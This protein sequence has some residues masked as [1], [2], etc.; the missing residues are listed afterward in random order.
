MALTK[1]KALDA[2]FQEFSALLANKM[3]LY[4]PKERWGEL[5]KK[6]TPV[7]HAS[8]C[9]DM[10]ACIRWLSNHLVKH[11]YIPEL[12]Y[13]LTIGETYFFRDSRLFAALEQEVLP[14]IIK[15][16]EE[17]RQIRI[18]SAGCCTGE[19]PYS[20]AILL[21]RLIPDIKDWNIH[22][23]ASDINPSFLFK[24]QKGEYSKWSFRTTP[25]DILRRYFVSNRQGY[26][27]IPEIQQMVTFASLN[28]VDPNTVE[29]S[30]S[31]KKMDLILCNN[32]LIYFSREQV[33]NTVRRL[34]DA[35]VTGGWLSVTAIEAPFIDH[36]HLVAQELQGAVLFRKDPKL[37]PK[38]EEA[39]ISQ[40]VAAII[41]PT[42]WPETDDSLL[43]KVV[44]PAFLK[45]PEPVLE[46]RFAASQTTKASVPTVEQSAPS[47]YD[48]CVALFKQKF[49]E[50]T[51]TGLLDCL[52]GHEKDAITLQAKRQEVYLLIRTY[53]NQGKF[54]EA[55]DWCDRALEADR[56]DPILH[57]LQ[58]E[59]ELAQGNSIAAQKALKRALFLDPNFVMAYYMLGVMDL[60]KSR[61]TLE[62][63]LRLVQ[64][65]DPDA[66]L[67]GTEET[68]AGHIK[69]H[70]TALLGRS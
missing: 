27:L 4:Y 20:L 37:M 48:A 28:L 53:A 36:H 59:V 68:T 63:A 14:T 51:V 17:D 29:V 46:Y 56:L 6:L 26:E 7:L 3:G 35:M 45:I 2:L 61:K 69:D 60:K 32:V 13:H 15:G 24:A 31:T 18:W 22:I 39:K 5:E 70:L 62:M 30:E 23:F 67:P 58:A 19:E 12:A 10:T 1:N 16:H 34:A 40:K 42:P 52:S 11:Q 50:Q 55:T 41:V 8:G 49:Y 57:Y 64:G 47:S 65:Y 38:V 44:L 9:S 54:A 21:H 43:L 25:H 66:T 33:M